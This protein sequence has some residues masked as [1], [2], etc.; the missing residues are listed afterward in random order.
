M[1]WYAIL[2]EQTLRKCHTTPVLL[3]DIDKCTDIMALFVK[4]W[5]EFKL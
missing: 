3:D 4:L 1:T 2:T 5:I